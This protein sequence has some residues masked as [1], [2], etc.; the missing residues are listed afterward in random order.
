MA[1]GCVFLSAGLCPQNARSSSGSLDEPVS[2]TMMLRVTS[3]LDDHHREKHFWAGCLP[4]KGGASERA[5]STNWA[6][7]HR[8]SEPA[9]ARRVRDGT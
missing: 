3:R 6:G 9:P 8:N 2:R 5:G 7:Q 4:R 1:D